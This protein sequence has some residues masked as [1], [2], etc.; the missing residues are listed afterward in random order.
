MVFSFE[1]RD[2]I[3]PQSAQLVEPASTAQ[4]GGE[5]VDSSAQVA[6]S[7]TLARHFPH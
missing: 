1:N 7:E 2:Q 6:S 5:A 3:S 4:R